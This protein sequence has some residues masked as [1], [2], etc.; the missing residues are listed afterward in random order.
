MNWGL[1]E[2]NREHTWSKYKGRVAKWP[3]G[4]VRERQ[5]HV[6]IAIGIKMHQGWTRGLGPLRSSEE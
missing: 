5:D 4:R 2:N 3:S 1:W 6:I